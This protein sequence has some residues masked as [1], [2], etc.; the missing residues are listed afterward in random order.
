MNLKR[1][2]INLSLSSWSWKWHGILGAVGSHHVCHTEQA[3]EKSIL[4]GKKKETHKERQRPG[5]ELSRFPMVC[6]LLFLL[7]SQLHFCSWNLRHT[8]SFIINPL[9]L[10]KRAW[11]RLL[12]LET[13]GWIDRFTEVLLSFT[14]GQALSTW[15]WRASFLSFVFAQHRCE[16]VA[17]SYIWVP[18]FSP[19]LSPDPFP[20]SLGFSLLSVLEWNANKETRKDWEYNLYMPEAYEQIMGSLAQFSRDLC[21]KGIGHKKV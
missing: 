21:C 13:P 10:L 18:Q 14:F 1:N 19:S 20:A 9:F 17:V 12:L 16:H 3:A 8:V 4:P 2:W 15:A 6:Q 5:T 7:L 11:V